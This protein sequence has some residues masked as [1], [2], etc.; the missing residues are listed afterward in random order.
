MPI[1]L[2][3]S[4]YESSGQMMNTILSE[5]LEPKDSCGK[6]V[7][8]EHFGF[9]VSESDIYLTLSSQ[10]QSFLKVKKCS[11]RSYEP[12]H[13]YYLR[14]YTLFFLSNYFSF[15]L[16]RSFNWCGSTTICLSRRVGRHIFTCKTI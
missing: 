8:L 12:L 9:V 1:K 7:L 2:R 3:E 16:H 10:S 6:Y 15:V 14:L 13:T 5:L 4:E 11:N